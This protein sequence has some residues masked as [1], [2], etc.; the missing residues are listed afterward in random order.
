[1]LITPGWGFIFVN[2]CKYVNGRQKFFLSLYT[3]NGDE[4]KTIPV[5]FGIEKGISWSNE[6]GFDFIAILTKSR[7][8][9]FA[10]EAFYMN[11]ADQSNQL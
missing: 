5:D 1:M 10:F 3:I 7:N 8:K 6:S 9:I 4:I 2:S 11:V